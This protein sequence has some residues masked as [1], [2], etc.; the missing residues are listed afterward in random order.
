M[1]ILG[2]RLTL[3]LSFCMLS[4]LACG[5]GFFDLKVNDVSGLDKPW[6]LIASLAFPEGLLQ[7][8][9]AIRIMSG[10]M[11]VPS[12]VDVA[13]VWRDGSIRWALAGFTSSPQAGYTVEYGKGVR[14]GEYA[15]PLK[16]TRQESG[17]FS[18]DTGAAFYLFESDKLL[19]ESAWLVSGGRRTHILGDSGAGA[20]LLDNS[21]RTARVSGKTAGVENAFLKEGPGRLV[22]KRSGWY[23]TGQGERLARAE[24]WLYFSAGSPYVKITHSIIFTEDTNK[25][26]VKDYGLEF[27]TPAGPSD[28][29][30]SIGEP[31]SD[32]VK[33]VRAAGEEVY[34]LQD[35]YPH[36]AEREYRAVIGVEGGD[37]E[38]YEVAGD[39][40][41][42]D[43][44]NHGITIV[45]PWL[46]ERFP[47]EISFG[48]GGARA[49]LWS[50][51][52]GSELDFRPKTLVDE[53]FKAWVKEGLNGYSEKS[54]ESIASNAQGAARTHDIWFLPH[55]GRYDEPMV[56]KSAVAAAR[57]PLAIAD[58]AWLCRTEAMA[59]HPML[60]RDEERFPREEAVI[61][62]YWERLILP[63]QVFPMKGFIAW[64]CYP[65]RS[66]REVGEKIMSNHH[67]LSNLRE[68]GLRVEPWRLYMRSGERVYYDYGHR[69]SRFTGDWHVSHMDVP[70][71][72]GKTRGGFTTTPGGRGISGKLPLFWGEKG[73]P[74]NIN[75]GE[76]RHWLFEYYLTGDERSLDLMHM[77]KESFK[78]D[79]WD[80]R[81]GGKGY[82]VRTLLALA[83][84]D[85]DEEALDK[86]KELARG[87]IDMD[88]Q[89]PLRSTHKDYLP[90]YNLLAYYLE[91]GDEIA[92]EA[93]LKHADQRYRFD[94]RF[95]PIAYKNFDAF[96]YTL[97][98]MMT[99][100]ER[101]RR[102]AE[103]T[104]ADLVFYPAEYPLSEELKMQPEKKLDWP[105]IYTPR[106]NFPGPRRS[107]FLAHHEYHNPFIGMPAVLKLLAEKGWSGEITPLIVK[108]V[109][110]PGGMVLFPHEKGRKTEMSL[111]VRF[112]SQEAEFN[113]SVFS[114][115][116]L[117]E[118]KYVKG[119]K[120]KVEKQELAR[121]EAYDAYDTGKGCH[122]FLTLPAE[123]DTG[124]YLFSPGDETT[125]TLLD[126]TG[127]KAAL[128]CPEGFWSS[129]YG[130]HGDGTRIMWGRSGQG[131]LMFFR[132]PEGLEELKIFLGIPA[133]VMFPDGSTAVEMLNEN[134][135]T[136]TIP[137]KG[138]NG[139]W[140]I[141]PFINSYRGTNPP[142]F[143]RLLNVEPVVA[144][145]SPEVLPEGTR[146]FPVGQ[147]S[148]SPVTVEPFGFIDGLSGRALCL[149][150]ERRL[151]F[152]RGERVGENG[153]AFFPGAKG[154][155]EFWFRADRSTQEIPMEMNQYKDIIFL[156]GPHISCSYRYHVS[157]RSNNYYSMLRTEL[158]EKG[159]D[160]SPAGFQVENL[161]TAGEWNHYAFTWD[162]KE[163]R[164][165][166]EG[167]LAIF[168]NG[169]KADA[170]LPFKLSRFGVSRMGPFPSGRKFA[171]ADE[172][173]KVSIGPL[174][175]AMDMLRISDT[176]RY[177]EDFTP[178]KKAP[179]MDAGTRA[180]FLFNG[181]L[182]G[183][184]AFSPGSVEAR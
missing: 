78:K 144:L 54:L 156:S 69:F 18:V 167:E 113:P 36:F 111:Y 150:G 110:K 85:W 14:R 159:K 184:S 56:R 122:V 169:K 95:Q 139:I 3:F 86:A 96:T 137:A 21:G 19:P 118:I 45:M 40:A 145:G 43:Y 5:A 165:G 51:R 138:K 174:E 70:G 130:E 50:G 28:V 152:P 104:A 114:Y 131:R 155:V 121:W 8:A 82:M 105:N 83:V 42:G 177:T 172:N 7:D 99:G 11:E 132:V 37:A 127:N 34:M 176:V 77:I 173:D 136:M 39:W 10:G 17:G 126:I 84:M 15:Q 61:S 32:E 179:A 75:S 13:A 46:A 101:Y 142:S 6:P 90:N 109:R 160:T 41:H 182:K 80:V 38:E 89:I 79:N 27:K 157:V 178:V 60:H 87:M 103:Q 20:Y 183:T 63:L 29:Y 68:Y 94:R 47:K 128:Y 123:T 73:A 135:G 65:D 115:G 72:S 57:P 92:R 25:V 134:I 112:H 180:L 120:T 161:L 140:S 67:A 116:S 171:L 44:G 52:S 124:L 147:E 48:P 158:R 55:G 181:S 66:Y 58:P 12:Q 117:P 153:Y 143:F 31:G 35:T 81:E 125:Y 175:G 88:S 2:G 170:A 59:S 106:E 91:T 100:D 108:P 33:H 133:K 162:V 53:Y 22:V 146:D 93:F 149:S 64:G 1:K 154:T 26:W 9:S 71:S 4:S 98:Y 168:V 97:A 62:E 16:V 164:K 24:A 141:K 166:M 119:V 102:A 76:I 49:V 74:H 129:T 107:F 23:V 163:G 151:S 30:C 148:M